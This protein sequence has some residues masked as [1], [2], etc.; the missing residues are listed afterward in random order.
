MPGSVVPVWCRST[1]SAGSCIFSDGVVLA[2]GGFEV[3][4]VGRVTGSY[5]KVIFYKAELY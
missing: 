1:E 5:K 4:S 2:Q 3:F